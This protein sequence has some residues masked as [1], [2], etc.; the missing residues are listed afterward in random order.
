MSKSTKANF[1]PK[2]EVSRR[3][4]LKAAAA[5]A[6]ASAALTVAPLAIADQA[7]APADAASV[8]AAADGTGVATVRG[9]GGDVTVTLEVKD[10]AIVGCEIVGESETPDRGGRAIESMQQAYL[11][12]GS[13]EVEGVAGATVTSDAVASAAKQAFAQA[14]GAASG[15]GSV[16]MQP[17][18]YTGSSVGYWG[19]WELPVTVTVNE[20]SILAIEVPE[21]RDLQ[22][23]TEGFFN[24]V[25]ERL[26]PRIIKNQSTAVDTVT[27]CTASSNA[28]LAAVDKA[29]A[30]ALEAGGSDA[31]ALEAFHRVPEKAEVGVTETV[32]CD[33]CVV[34]LSMAGILAT[35]AALE[36]L[37][38]Y[39]ERSARIN[40]FG[41][42]KCGKLGG[43]SFM[44]HSPNIV[45]PERRLADDEDP[46]KFRCDTEVLRADW[47]AHTMGADGV[48]KAK[49][50]MV[51]LFIAETGN[52]LDWIIYDL[53]WMIGEPKGNTDFSTTDFASKTCWY[54][55]ANS[56]A[57]KFYESNEDR[58][59][60]VLSYF[61]AILQESKG[62][63]GGFALETEAYELVYD[64]AERRV[65]GVKA[66]DLV[67]GK[68]IE[69]RCNAVIMST[70]GYGQNA[71]LMNT[72]LPPKLAGSWFQNGNYCNDGKM[73]QAALNIGAGT[74]NAD[75]PPCC[76][77]ISLPRYMH[78]FPIEFVEGKITKRTGRQTTKT[79]ND[80][81]MYMCVSID[82]LAVGPDGERACNEY[83][84]ANGI[85]DRVPPD[86]WVVGP[87]FYSIWSQEQVDRLAETGFTSE[88]V[89]RTVAY[90]QQG[91]FNLDEPR[92]EMQEA[93][94]AAV[95][96]GL[97][98]KADTL[99]E[100]AAQLD[101]PA[102]TLVATVERYNGFC[103]AGMDED[104]GKEAQWLAPIGSGPYYA[105]KAMNAMYGTSG[106]LD[107]DT[108]MNVLM[109][110]GTTPIAGLYA[111]GQDTFGV[112][113]SPDQNYIG[114][115]GV[116]QGWQVL[117]GRLMG[118][119]AAK[120]VYE[121]FG[122]LSQAGKE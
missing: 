4:F 66:R 112:I 40:I 111:G 54:Y 68:E 26:F 55:Y 62:A 31:S 106:G 120:Y 75:V 45:N 36:Q 41:I 12:T 107:V 8:G 9:F 89:K 44:T 21:T 3:G 88:N 108:G 19:I 11:E 67:T 121:N 13:L 82:S 69:V 71:E 97:A 22:G 92:P 99:E 119:N 42:E 102:E 52:T 86:T 72:L 96:E 114:Y 32:D 57:D 100:L 16:H 73:F 104:F 109:A 83:G 43:Q 93:M 7:A 122:L 91:G 49:E 46:D 17:G 6:A 74:Y 25:K 87:Y 28:V 78:H 30:Q 80:I 115:G 1:A 64:E 98:W 95:E 85:A 23:E 77:E 116:C 58:R 76:M 110:D 20:T 94:D 63:G 53:G 65:T 14:T 5:G 101:M 10:G 15:D 118:E 117:T 113:Q 103:S 90:C 35:K 47:L 61:D 37:L 39:S 59:A 50:E 38:K 51:D 2:T 70:G 60:V 27:G 34:G 81:P 105:I 33:I 56:G 79:L 29:L 84:I 18:A 48:Q 24:P